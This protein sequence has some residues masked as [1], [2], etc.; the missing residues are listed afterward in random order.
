MKPA[1]TVR[2]SPGKLNK[3]FMEVQTIQLKEKVAAEKLAKAVEQVQAS[4]AAAA[5]AAAPGADGAK[6]VSPLKGVERPVGFLSHLA[7]AR[8]GGIA[9]TLLRVRRLLPYLTSTSRL[10]NLGRDMAWT[11][12]DVRRFQESVETS[13]DMFESVLDYVLPFFTHV[14]PPVHFSLCTVFPTAFI[15]H[16]AVI[17]PCAPNRSA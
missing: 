6:K 2:S 7:L 5:A 12:E 3:L 15:P 13:K 10:P 9:M 8:W 17:H 4:G 16:S 1:N 14:S 11:A